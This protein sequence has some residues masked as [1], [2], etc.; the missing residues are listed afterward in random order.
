M[1]NLGDLKG[2]ALNVTLRYFTFNVTLPPMVVCGRRGWEKTNVT[3][4]SVYR[5]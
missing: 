2:F 3:R 5:L 1:P 4:S